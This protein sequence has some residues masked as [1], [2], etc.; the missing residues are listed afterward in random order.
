MGMLNAIA[1]SRVYLDANVVIYA[2]EGFAPTAAA[3]Q[4]LFAR[5]DRGELH[6]ITSEL[7]LAE[8]LVK[9]IRDSNP[10]ARDAYERL[11]RSSA[12]L[13]V[14]PVTR[15]VLIRAAVIRASSTLKLPDASHAATALAAACTTFLTNDQGFAAVA[16][17]PVLPLSRLP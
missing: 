6:A 11:L 2:I 12:A 7:T 17:L 1:G 3:L 8:T 13:T 10:S 4:A 5:F 15:D 9:P 16:A 14:A